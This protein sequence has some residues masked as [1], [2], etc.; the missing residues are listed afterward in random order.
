MGRQCRLAAVQPRDPGAVDKMRPAHLTPGQASC[1]D[2]RAS[3]IS[4]ICPTP[5]PENCRG[6]RA[7]RDFPAQRAT[8][9]DH[10]APYPHALQGR[11][12]PPGEAQRNRASRGRSKGPPLSSHPTLQQAANPLLC[13]LPSC[14]SALSS[15]PT[16][17]PSKIRRR[18]ES[19]H[20]LHPGSSRV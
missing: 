13:C 3:G 6:D 11:P 5:S 18:F 15:D 9:T 1:R 10:T 8:A 20:I 17:T 4:E 16:N 14:H 19:V 12:Q 2:T 7:G